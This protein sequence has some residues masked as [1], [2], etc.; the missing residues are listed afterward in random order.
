[1]GRINV[2]LTSKLLDDL[3]AESK[4]EKTN[5]SALIRTA[6][7][8]YIEA[9]QRGREEEEKRK[10]MQ[11]ASRKMDALAKKLGKW[12]AQKILRKFRDSNLK[13]AS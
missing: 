11:E 6:L 13:G 10:K 12:D 5:R 3:D 1:M 9:K 4:R 7:E 8:K 2:F